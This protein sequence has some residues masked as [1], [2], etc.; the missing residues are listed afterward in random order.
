MLAPIA[1][2]TYG[3]A[4][5]LT[6]TVTG[7]LGPAT[8]TV[9]FFDGSPTSGGTEI[10]TAPVSTS[11]GLATTSVSSLSV[12]GSPHQIYALYVP[13]PQVFTY[14]GST[15][16]PQSV[17]VNPATLTVSGVTVENKQYDSTTTAT[18][19]TSG[20]TLNGVI[21]TDNVTLNTMNASAAFT[22]PNAGINIPVTV[23][24]LSLSGTAS[25]NY[26][27]QQPTGLTADITQAPLTLTANNQTMAQGGAVPALT[28]TGTG[29]KG[30]DTVAVLT[31]QPTLSTTATSS[32][33]AGTYPINISGGTAANYTITDVPG[34][35]TVVT[36]F[37]TTTTLATSMQ[38]AVF[39]QPITFTATVASVS[40]AAGKPTGTVA[41]FDGND[42]LGESPLN[43]STGTATFTTSSLGFGRSSIVAVF[44]ANPPF[45]NSES[46]AVT[47]LVTSTG[48]SPTLTLV[49]VRN[50]HGKLIA[51]DLVS[52]VVPTPPGS[53]TPPGSVT[54]FRN[55]RAFY[56][57][58]PLS[59]GTAV[60]RM[61]PGRL[62]NKFVY[63]RYNGNPSF[64]GSA[65]SNFYISYKEIALLARNS[66][67]AKVA[68]RRG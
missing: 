45:Q 65:S 29:F 17:I 36:S 51:V 27:L 22:S 52:Q 6:A 63:V 18:L 54:F 47:Q 42:L 60:L 4:V 37:G 62:I 24:G 16:A 34:T 3:Q 9:E 14:A 57:S 66:S 11:T 43:A 49:P 2:D 53:G 1:T 41:F 12:T 64:V 7:S 39:G 68:H 46:N 40:P 21:G 8:G 10:A 50:K 35:L 13:T 30:T 55:G 44:I 20:A 58:V 33:P 19:N 31:T 5:T 48:T 28:F 32:S 23:T 61:S 26:V 56:R 67:R 38:L 25:D 15:S 59:N